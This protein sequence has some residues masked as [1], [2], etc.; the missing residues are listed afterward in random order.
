MSK[1]YVYLFS[2]GN[3]KM[4]EL[5]GGK[6]ANLA[7][8][9]GF[10]EGDDSTYMDGKMRLHGTGSEDYYNGGWY[11]ML[12]RWDRGVSLPLHGSLD[13]S[14]PMARTG[15]YRFYM[16]D[17]LSFEREFYMGIEHGPSGNEYPV[18][19]TS[20]AFFYGET[21]ATECME[22]TQ[23]LRTVCIPDRHTFYPQAMR[24]S[25]GN[26]A[27][28]RFGDFP[29]GMT[30]SSRGTG[31]VRVLLEDVPEG[32]YRIYFDYYA[33]PNGAEF[34][35]WQRQGM[36]SD[37]RSSKAQTEKLV[38]RFYAGDIVLTPQTNSVSFQI[39]GNNYRSEFEFANIYL[40][41]IPE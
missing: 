7:E 2:E 21:P 38:S 29:R 4:R 28:V 31:L 18:D 20:V 6:G 24:L 23:R 26:N 22:P 39:R 12:D 17:K 37:W 36:L 10:F 5:L 15:G 13:Y 41:R 33:K 35:V 32:R 9:T 14:L 25:L 1:K 27:Q 16:N 30:V 8:M 3:A 19:Y 40:E 34:S 11:A